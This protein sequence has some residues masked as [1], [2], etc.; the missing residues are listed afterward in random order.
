VSEGPTACSASPDAWS[1]ISRDSEQVR[2]SLQ[3]VPV[4]K[5]HIGSSACERPGFGIEKSRFGV[6]ADWVML[7]D[8]MSS[9]KAD[10]H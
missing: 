7:V 8:R 2:A 1:P 3:D 9:S 4:A 5:Q 6:V 10:S